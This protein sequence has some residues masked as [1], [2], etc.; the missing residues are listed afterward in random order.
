MITANLKVTQPFDDA[1][2]GE[3]IVPGSIFSTHDLFRA[4][5]I[6]NLGYAKLDSVSCNKKKSGNRVLV[7]TTLLY[8]IGGIETFNKHIARKFADQDIVFVTRRAAL[9]QAFSLGKLADLIIDDGK[10]EY[11]ADVCILNNYDSAEVILDRVKARKIYQFVHGD[12]SAITSLPEWRNFK[13]SPDERVDLC[14]TPS[15]TAQLGLKKKFNI[16]SLVV[17]NPLTPIPKDP[18]LT[19]LVLSRA[20]SEKG[21]D[22]VVRLAQRLHQAGKYF[23]MLMA[24]TLEQMEKMPDLPPEVVRVEPT[25]NTEPLFR[26]ADYL[27][28]L[29]KTESYGYSPREA[30]QHSVPVIASTAPELTKL[31]K[32]GENGYIVEDVET[33]DLEKLWK[34]PI[35]KPYSEK[36]SPLWAKLLKGEL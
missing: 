20:T 27:V 7:Y 10:R 19:L 26:S 4:E 22:A 5:K 1:L 29:S 17:P 6:I 30:L 9:G 24:S 11:E 31:I 34:K 12:L 25:V 21:M 2:T 16:D 28:Q 3:H 18:P 8:D 32:D 15:E 36:I 23:V 13:W 35:V 14:I 33:F